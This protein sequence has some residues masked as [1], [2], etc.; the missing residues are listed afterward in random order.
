M[1][2]IKITLDILLIFCYDYNTI[3]KLLIDLESLQIKLF[4]KNKFHIFY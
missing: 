3:N 4:S 1:Y 2:T